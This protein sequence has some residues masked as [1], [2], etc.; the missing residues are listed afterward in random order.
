MELKRL[1]GMPNDCLVFMPHI[2]YAAY[3][4]YDINYATADRIVSLKS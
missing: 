2:N 1:K 4:L 3:N